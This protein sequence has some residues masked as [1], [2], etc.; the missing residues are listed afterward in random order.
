MGGQCSQGG[1]Y[2]VDQPTEP[3][4]YPSEEEIDAVIAAWGIVEKEKLSLEIGRRAFLKLFER[5]PAALDVFFFQ[6]EPDWENGDH[7]NH[8]CAVVVK[9]LGHV[10]KV[11]RDQKKVDRNVSVLGAKHSTF[12]IPK[13]QFDLLGEDLMV[14]FTEVLG[15]RFT[16]IALVGWKKLYAVITGLIL[17]SMKVHHDAI[18]LDYNKK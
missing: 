9:L 6:I 4:P 8:H 7:F 2:P 12:R 15:D 14:A 16:P 11:I 3:A 18:M 5:H 13:V 10:V 17:A 1:I